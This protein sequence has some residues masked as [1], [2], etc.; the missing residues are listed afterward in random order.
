MEKA[1]KL[2]LVVP[3]F[4]WNAQDA[5]VMW[6]I[7]PYNLC[8][9]AAMVEDICEV[10][11]LDA[12]DLDLS[13]EDFQAQIAKEQPDL[14]GISVLMD[15]C[16]AAG[17]KAAELVKAVNS[18]IVVHMGGVYP[19]V[20]PEQAMDDANL[21]M[22]I[23]GEGEYV[24]REL[25]EHYSSGTDLPE[26]GICFR[27][28]GKLV[29][30]GRAPLIEDPGELPLPAYKYIDYASYSHSAARKSVD[31]PPEFP[32]ARILTSRG[33]P[34]KCNFCQVDRISGRKFRARSAEN[35]LKEIAWL[36][37][38]YG[39]RSLIFDDDNLFANKK[40]AL[41]IFQGMIDQGLDLPWKAISTAVF[42]LDEELL[43][44]M[45]KSGCQ[46]IDVAIESGTERVLKEVIQKPVSLA[47]AKQMVK[48][49]RELGIYVAANF[50]VGFPT[51]TWDEI[52]RTIGFAEE[53]EADYVKI[54]NAIPL[55]HTRLWEQCE[56][57][58]AF[59]EDFDVDQI[60]W[61]AGQIETE[62]F[63]PDDLTVLRAF[64]WERIN[65][66][67]PEKQRKTAEI[68]K[69]SVDELYQIRRDTLKS[70]IA[71]LRAT[72]K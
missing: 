2:L 26:Q 54:F 63:T 65:F 46:Y 12:Y 9:L 15:Q 16:A 45:R 42:H 34:Q 55:R 51:E 35:V 72:G 36:K 66:S 60:S 56:E 17:H 48:V 49:A 32:Y 67:S 40:R 20:S 21:D 1:L 61:F 33:C 30:R 64:E 13:A 11:I 10:S 71:H 22:V 14:V 29:N 19:T 18:D 59:K 50:I 5:R 7:T 27:E 23:I 24:L 25:I 39:I 43:A 3:N 47:Y 4:R 58:G 8:L 53:L 69:I 62:H 28:N 68:M 44:L 41:A 6:H 38:E 70:A 52:R 31:S 57:A 37:E